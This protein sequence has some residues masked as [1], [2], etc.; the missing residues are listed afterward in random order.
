MIDSF[1]GHASTTVPKSNNSGTNGL[2]TGFNG[3]ALSSGAERM[4][5]SGLWG[6]SDLTETWRQN[7]GN[8]KHDESD[9]AQN[10]AVPSI[11]NFFSNDVQDLPQES[12]FNWDSNT[13]I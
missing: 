12:R 8:D 5:S 6:S 7:E 2:L 9:P 1:F 11:G 10:V 4:K 13:N 3:L